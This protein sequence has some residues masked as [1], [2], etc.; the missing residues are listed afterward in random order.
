MAKAATGWA[1]AIDENACETEIAGSCG[2][3]VATKGLTTFEGKLLE[4]RGKGI[5]AIVGRRAKGGGSVK[6]AGLTTTLLLSD[7]SFV[8]VFIKLPL[9]SSP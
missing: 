3:R 5:G 9:R 6:D 7:V 4:E 1:E 8:S 2:G